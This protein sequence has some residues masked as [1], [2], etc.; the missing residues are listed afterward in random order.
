MEDRNKARHEL[1][2]LLAD[3]KSTQGQILRVK[4]VLAKRI[5]NGPNEVAEICDKYRLTQEQT[6]KLLSKHHGRAAAIEAKA[7]RAARGFERL[8]GQLALSPEAETPAV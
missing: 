5:A 4:I 8:L 6:E 3:P 1:R 2:S 7:E